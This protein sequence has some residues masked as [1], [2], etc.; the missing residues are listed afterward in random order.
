MFLTGATTL[1]EGGAQMKV[2]AVIVNIFVPGVGSLIIGKIGTGIIQLILYGLGVLFSL[3]GI[4][5]IVGGP[6]CLVV[7]IWGIITAATAQVKPM[8]VVVVKE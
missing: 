6:I 7:W 3:T 1:L 5:V 4:G 2:L 8:Q